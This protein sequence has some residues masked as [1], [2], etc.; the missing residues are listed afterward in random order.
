M[1]GTKFTFKEARLGE[2]PNGRFRLLDLES[3]D[4]SKALVDIEF[5]NRK[6]ARNWARS[7]G[8]Q[9]VERA[10]DGSTMNGSN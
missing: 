1:Q 8:Y 3:N 9:I 4:P 2:Q 6:A 7:R 5:N 10:P